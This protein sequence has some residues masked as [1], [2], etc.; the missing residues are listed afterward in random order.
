MLEDIFH[1]C[2][3][4]GLFFSFSSL[5]PPHPS[6]ILAYLMRVIQRHVSQSYALVSLPCLNRK[7]RLGITDIEICGTYNVVRNPRR[8]AILFCLCTSNFLIDQ[9]NM[10]GTYF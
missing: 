6:F 3:A 5:P 2:S 10:S 4:I 7:G 8:I 9:V 1:H